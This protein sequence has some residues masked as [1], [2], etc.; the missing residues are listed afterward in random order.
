MSFKSP[1]QGAHSVGSTSPFTVP[2]PTLHSPYPSPLP[3]PANSPVL[4]L[5][6]P[7]SGVCCSSPPATKPLLLLPQS[8]ITCDLWLLCPYPLASELGL[9]NAPNPAVL[10]PYKS[11]ELS[12]DTWVI[13][14]PLIPESQAYYFTS[15]SFILKVEN[16]S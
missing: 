10:T 11:I 7:C 8:W 14:L 5:Q 13:V 9:R 4:I 12:E 1:G 2:I 15:L 3:A 16:D 6:A